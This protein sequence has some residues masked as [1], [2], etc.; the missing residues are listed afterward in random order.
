M[1]P[2]NKLGKVIGFL[3]GA[4]AILWAMRDRLV[5]IAAPQDPEPPRFRVVP[6]SGPPP[7]ED[8]LT[9]I[10]GIGPVFAGR[11]RDADIRTF[12][13]VATADVAR[14]VEVTGASEARAAEWISAA[15]AH[16]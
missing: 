9:A 13:D 3:G 14:L 15:S 4:L 10:S 1:P 8:D 5:S 2:V 16:V 6:P 12:S 11:L 7:V